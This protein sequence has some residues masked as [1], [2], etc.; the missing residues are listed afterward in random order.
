M[1]YTVLLR[2]RR[3]L[4]RCDLVASAHLLRH[5]RKGTTSSDPEIS[6]QISVLEI[7]HLVRSGSLD[8]AFAKLEQLSGDFKDGH[9]DVYARITVLNMKARLYAEVGKAHKGFSLALRA[10]SAAQKARLLPSMWTAVGLL[11][12]VLNQAHESKASQRLLDSVIPQALEGGDSHQCA[13]LYSLQAD[14]YIALANDENTRRQGSMMGRVEV[15]A[16]LARER[17]LSCGLSNPPSHSCAADYK[18]IEDINGECEMLAK[19]AVISRWRG[20]QRLADDWAANYVATHE[21]AMQ[22]NRE[23][24]DLPE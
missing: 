5:V 22:R 15:Y 7:E 8:A 6:F 9:A 3:A 23:E 11:A 17:K 10:A 2:L 18:R 4:R 14:V 20:D 24:R 1:T 13:Y 21:K 16:D 12:N 19:K